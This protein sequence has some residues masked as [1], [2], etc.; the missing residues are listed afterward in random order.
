[1]SFDSNVVSFDSDLPEAGVAEWQTRW[2]QNPVIAR[3]CGFKSLRRQDNLAAAAFRQGRKRLFPD[4]YFFHEVANLTAMFKKSLQF[5]CIVFIVSALTTARAAGPA[6]EGS[7]ADRNGKSVAGADVRIEQSGAKNSA[8][9]V[10]TDGKG[11]YSCAGLAANAKYRVTVLLNGAPKATL[12]VS[13]GAGKTELNFNLDNVGVAS[14]GPSKGK[15]RVWV[16][17]KAGSNLGGHWEE[18]DNDDTGNANSR[19]S[20]RPH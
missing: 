19:A 13:T 4:V 6:L 18:V 11:R 17:P 9:M 12:N 10:K 15:H 2:T 1:L 14:S 7:V 8:K 5:S 16:E 3:S 20:D